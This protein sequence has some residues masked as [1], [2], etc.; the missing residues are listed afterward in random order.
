MKVHTQ[1]AYFSVNRLRGRDAQSYRELRLEGLLHE[2]KAFGASWAD[3]ASQDVHRFAQR[4]E[5]GLIF[6]ARAHGDSRLIGSAA[7]QIPTADKL[8]HKAALWGV[9][10]RPE[11]RRLGAGTALLTYVLD[12][13]STR[14]EEVTLVVGADNASALA[15]YRRAGFTE[16]GLERRA[17]KIDDRYYDERLMAVDVTGRTATSL[18]ATDNQTT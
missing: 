17:L 12:F 13:A 14:V 11:A 8:K 4:L 3:E 15:M 7:I 5:D 2:P 9:Y 1:M 10:V 6:G 16:Y 18:S